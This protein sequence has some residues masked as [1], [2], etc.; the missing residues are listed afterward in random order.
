M[1]RCTPVEEVKAID[2]QR[3]Y[4]A[5]N[6]TAR[7]ALPNDETSQY[8]AGEGLHASTTGVTADTEKGTMTAGSASSAYANSEIGVTMREEKVR[9]ERRLVRKLG[10]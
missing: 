3:E 10:E 1:T 4:A 5:T 6:N 7:F 2:Q 9:I 8:A